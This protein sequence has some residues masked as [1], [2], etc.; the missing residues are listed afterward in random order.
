M[1]D[2]SLDRIEAERRHGPF[3][4]FEDFYLR[5]RVDYPVAENLI[6]VGAFDSLEPDRTEL[7]GDFP[8]CTIAWKRWPGLRDRG[9]ANCGHSFPRPAAPASNATGATRTRS[10]SELELLGLTV[11]RHP[12][13]LYE[14]ELRRLGVRLSYELPAMGDEVPVTVAGVYERAQN[15]RMRS[16]SAPCSSPW[17]TPTASSS[18]SASSRNCR[19]SP[20]WSP[21]ELLPVRG[22]LQNNRKRGLAIVAEE[23][24]DLEEVRRGDGGG[25]AANQK[26]APRKP[27][28]SPALPPMPEP[29]EMIGRREVE[30][31]GDG[32]ASAKKRVLGGTSAIPKKGGNGLSVQFPNPL[33]ISLPQKPDWPGTNQDPLL[34]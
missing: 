4:S 19:R 23:V 22:R 2:R 12:L 29:V 24:L 34:F 27:L 32:T 5:T 20:R 33:A 10:C 15:P 18:A 8:C 25:T 21:G 30:T 1:G 9:A 13:Q 26:R 11:T 6:R 14:D 17:R 7:L 31:Y 28:V 3:T 16:A